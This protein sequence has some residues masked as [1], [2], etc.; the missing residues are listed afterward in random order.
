MNIILGIS[1]NKPKRVASM[2]SGE[3]SSS[4]PDTVY[5]PNY[6]YADQY[7]SMRVGPE[8]QT[9]GAA[10]GEPGVQYCGV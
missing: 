5:A 1:T 3:P 8:M 6:R 2:A 9:A 10:P 7:A 4:I